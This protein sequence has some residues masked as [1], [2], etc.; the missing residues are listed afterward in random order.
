MLDRVVGMDSLWG[1][2]VEGTDS[3]AYGDFLQMCGVGGVVTPNDH[4]EIHRLVNERE[5]GVLPLLGGV[6][7]GVER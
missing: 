4:H 5:H 2:D 1:I 7:D 6:A 3:A